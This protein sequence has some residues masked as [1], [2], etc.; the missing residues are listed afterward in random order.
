M[1]SALVL[2][3]VKNNAGQNTGLGSAVHEVSQLPS[4]VYLQLLDGYSVSIYSE[5]R[6]TANG[7]T[8]V[9]NEGRNRVG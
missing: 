5:P 7:G 8:Y 6:R 9:H 1:A 4:T 2:T 3:A